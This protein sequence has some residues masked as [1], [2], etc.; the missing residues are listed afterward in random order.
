[1]YNMIHFSVKYYT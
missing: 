1:M